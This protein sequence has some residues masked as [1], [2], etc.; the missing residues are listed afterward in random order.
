VALNISDWSKVY[1]PP[2]AYID[3]SFIVNSA[4][5]TFEHGIKAIRADGLESLND[6]TIN[7]YNSFYLTTRRKISEIFR[8]NE[9]NNNLASI[10][11]PL[12]FYVSGTY[13]YLKWLPDSYEIVDA[14]DALNGTTR[15]QL[16]FVDQRIINIKHLVDNVEYRLVIDL[17]DSI[18]F[19]TT[20]TSTNFN[21]GYTI[22]SLGHLVLYKTLTEPHK[23]VTSVNGTSIQVRGISAGDVTKFGDS[24]INIDYTFDDLIYDLDLS[25]VSYDKTDLNLAKID[26]NRS[27]FSL[28]GQFLITTTYNNIY[29]GI[30]VNFITLKTNISESNVVKRG[31]VLNSGPINVPDTDFRF[32]TSLNTGNSQEKGNEDIVLTYSFFD[33]DIKVIPGTDTVFQTSSSIYP[34]DKLNINDAKFI[35]N[36]A[37]GSF[38]PAVSD[39][40]KKL[41]TNSLSFN[42]GRYL[43]TWLS[44]NAT[45]N[46][47]RWV[48]RYYYPD[49]VTRST[50]LSADLYN[51]SFEDPVDGVALTTIYFEQIKKDPV[52][53]KASDFFLEPDTKYVYQRISN[54]DFTNYI[55]GISAYNILSDKTTTQFAGNRFTTIGIDDINKTK[56]FTLTFDTYLNPNKKIGYSLLGNLTN[57]GF[58]ILNDVFITPILFTMQDTNLYMYNTDRIQVARQKFEKNIKDFVRF[59]GLDDFIVV[60][61]DGYVYNCRYDGTIT[62]LNVI[63]TLS[64][65][66]SFN[67]YE[68]KAAFVLDGAGTCLVIDN[69]TLNTSFSAS[70]NTGVGDISSVYYHISALYGV[71]GTDIRNYSSNTV[72]Y[73]YNNTIY[74]H[75]KTTYANTPV[76]QSTSAML[77]YAI[78]Q[79]GG[80]LIL[81]NTDVLGYYNKHR[82]NIFQKQLSALPLSGNRCEFVREYEET[83]INEFI[84]VA[85]IDE[86]GVSRIIKLDMFGNLS[87]STTVSGN[88]S[89]TMSNLTNYNYYVGR[90]DINSLQFKIRLQNIKDKNDI[91]TNRIDYDVSDK[92][93][94]YVNLSYVFDSVVG[95]ITLLVNSIPQQTFRFDPA[96]YSVSDIFND[97]IVVG[98]TGFYNGRTLG[99]FLKQPTHY[100]TTNTTLRNFYLFNK[101]LKPN[102]I[103]TITMANKSIDPLVISLPAGQRNN[104]EEVVRFFQFGV[105]NSHSNHITIQV[106]NS[107]IT[108]IDFQNAIKANI[109]NTIKDRLKGDIQ[110]DDIK[111]IDYTSYA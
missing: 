97:D 102:E 14:D 47:Y 24:L 82:S 68:N 78:D 22:D 32:Y 57:Y 43:C 64:S 51:P 25:W 10:T 35:Q 30:D 89:A 101:P 88:L 42:N 15:F 109:R 100:L 1:H 103:T 50:A 56:Q 106:K 85:G 58:S 40:I 79:Y 17:D 59:E 27:A 87:A 13:K 67:T 77:D 75:N 74:K 61:E 80:F 69:F 45:K 34:Y 107:Q 6:Q 73:L 83:N 71:I 49:L 31:A 90:S 60:C 66:T 21:L 94:G 93:E 91:Y 108:N 46:D 70:T 26:N 62:R 95:R 2:Y 98:G 48:D 12:R 84:T 52:F 29:D 105:P 38:S 110:I 99:Q 86:T 104:V 33:K 3:D 37:Y 39:R 36:G 44:A 54:S 19:A 20:A 72:C 111:F 96:K 28:P 11:T 18:Y 92:S 76:I 81:H 53:D 8:F 4:S 7:S 16:V 9:I 63:P 5:N 55:E 41:R 65:Y 23:I